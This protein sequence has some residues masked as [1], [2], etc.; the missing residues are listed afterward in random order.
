MDTG[1]LRRLEALKRKNRFGDSH[2]MGPEAPPFFDDFVCLFVPHVQF[3]PPDCLH[4]VFLSDDEVLF[5]TV[6]CPFK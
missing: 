5:Y 1:G 3:Y 6:S 4:L 2:G